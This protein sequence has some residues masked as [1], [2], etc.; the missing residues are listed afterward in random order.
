MSPISGLFVS[1]VIVDEICMLNTHTIALYGTDIMDL[2]PIILQFDAMDVT[3][4][5]SQD[6]T[7]PKSSP[8]WHALNFLNIIIW[9]SSYD[10]IKN[11]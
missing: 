11:M 10:L 7:N 2:C 6:N 9:D 5:K 1:I 4:L 8:P 3:T